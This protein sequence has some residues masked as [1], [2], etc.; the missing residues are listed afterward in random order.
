M[1]YDF[2]QVANPNI[3]TPAEKTEFIQ[4]SAEFRHWNHGNCWGRRSGN[5]LDNGF[6]SSSGERPFGGGTLVWHGG[7]E[8]MTASHKWD[9]HGP[10]QID[11][12]ALS[13]AIEK[14]E[15][16]RS[17]IT[18]LT[19]SDLSDM[20][21][22]MKW[23]IRTFLITEVFA[24]APGT[25]GG[26]GSGGRA[27]LGQLYRGLSD[28][29]PFDGWKYSCQHTA[30]VLFLADVLLRVWGDDYGYAFSTTDGAGGVN[31]SVDSRGSIPSDTYFQNP[32]PKT[33]HRAAQQIMR[34][35]IESGTNSHPWRFGH[36][37]DSST[38]Q[39]IDSVS[40]PTNSSR[41]DD[42]RVGLP[43][44]VY[45]RDTKIRD[46][47]IRSAANTPSPPAN[48]PS[49]Q[50]HPYAGTRGIWPG[51]CFMWAYTENELWPYPGTP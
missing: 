34:F 23:S 24:S 40:E 38:S 26:Q 36:K 11:C 14:V 32:G 1:I 51:I 4:W 17:G 25:N 20:M 48:P 45:F 33:L 7:P 2:S 44:N 43:Y 50:T 28:T 9:N 41:Y 39:R 27:G 31:G 47:Y 16:Q 49:G 35:V 5:I 8:E 13:A 10:A 46:I 30:R 3:W 42:L 22:W 18:S 37:T 21:S 19:D 15:R 6:P 29:S 12:T